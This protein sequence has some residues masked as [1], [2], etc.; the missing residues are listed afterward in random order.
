MINRKQ[1]LELLHFESGSHFVISFFMGVGVYKA[2]KKAFE[3][4]A[5]DIIREA[6]NKAD[7][8]DSE[9]E[10]V[11]ENAR[12]VLNFIKLE[13]E[14]RARGLA[15]FS[16]REAGLWQIYRLPVEVPEI[17]V[18][19][20]VPYISP[21]LKLVDESRK[22]CVVLA[23]KEKARL[24][25]MYLGKM[26]EGVDLFDVVPG[27]HKQGGWAQA[28][29]Q[30]HI[31]DL[32]NR[33]L[34]NVADAIFQYY[35]AEGFG[36]LIIGGPPEVRTRLVPVLHSYLQKIVAG[37][38]SVDVMAGP[39]EILK[40]ARQIEEETERREQDEI[41][42]RVLSGSAQGHPTITGFKNNLKALM[43]GRVHTLVLVDGHEVSGAYCDMCGNLNE[44]DVEA[45]DACDTVIKGA[46]DVSDRLATLAFEHD[47]EVKYVRGGLGLEK[48][49]GVGSI[50]RW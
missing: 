8:P 24:F 16:C 14:G 9:M 21:M 27:W 5:K 17:C 26:T 28:R 36:H 50:L 7:P 33:H 39:G 42:R 48:H 34:K 2:R 47:S 4:E 49:G 12:R 22:Y 13:F 10:N 20:H 18:V 11:R 44:A 45:C 40:A 1:I 31:D 46:A 41:V 29:F 30:R 15:I 35:K 32:V 43:A 38:I 37:S 6:I 3:I 19:N 25:T 23:D